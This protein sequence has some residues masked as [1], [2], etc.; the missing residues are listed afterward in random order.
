MGSSQQGEMFVVDVNSNVYSYKYTVGVTT[1][2]PQTT[3]TAPPTFPP[4]GRSVS[5]NWTVFVCNFVQF[6]LL[7]T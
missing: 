5:I 7:L 4:T 2:P 3:T 1:V 6:L